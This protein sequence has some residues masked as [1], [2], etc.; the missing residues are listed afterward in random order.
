MKTKI[1]SLSILA[2]LLSFNLSAQDK[3]DKKAKKPDP[4]TMRLDSL[5]AR[6]AE[7]DSK[8]QQIEDSNKQ[9]AEQNEKLQNELSETRNDIGKLNN[10]ITELAKIIEAQNAELKKITDAAKAGGGGSDASQKP[11]TNT[12]I[13]FEETTI[14]F[15]EVKEGANVTKIYKFKNTGKN[16]LL[17]ES[18]L[19]SCGCTVAEWPKY[20]VEP[21]E[22]A[23]VKV[24]FNSLG[25]RGAQDKTITI[26][27]NTDPAK[28]V[29]HIKGTVLQAE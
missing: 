13:A 25:K 9:L 21:G 1:I 6:L 19:G 29:L 24:V 10:K 11:S 5:A 18:A 26:L 23:E 8:Q 2:L 16:R 12:S 7:S 27:A 17:I 22:K 28:T 3:K 20:P 4:I 15:G 14:D